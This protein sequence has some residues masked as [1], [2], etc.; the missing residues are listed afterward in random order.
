[1]R[2][3]GES[4]GA[5]GVRRGAEAAAAVSGDARNIFERAVGIRGHVEVLRH[6]TF[7]ILECDAIVPLQLIQHLSRR[8]VLSFTMR[9]RNAHGLYPAQPRAVVLHLEIDPPARVARDACPYSVLRRRV[10]RYNR[11][12]QNPRAR[13]YLEA[14]ADARHEGIALEKFL[15]RLAQVLAH[16]SSVCLPRARMVAI[17][18]SAAKDNYLCCIEYRRIRDDVV[19][20]DYVCRCAHALER[21]L[22]FILSVE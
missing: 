13:D 2:Q 6:L 16:A 5:L 10:V 12:R 8:V 22:C 19:D 14:A 18:E 21:G 20:V 15:E 9:D 3:L 1:M 7:H 4:H 17:R 11:S